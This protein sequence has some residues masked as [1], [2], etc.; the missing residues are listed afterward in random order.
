MQLKKLI[1]TA[2][3]EFPYFLDLKF[4]VMRKIRAV[5]RRPFES[6]FAA[7]P[8]LRP[9]RGAEFIDVGANRGQSIEA[10]HMLLPE[11]IVR[12]FEP[13][14][15]LFNKLRSDFGSEPWVRLHNFGLGAEA[16]EAVLFV[17]FYKRW[18]FD[19]LA[20]FDEGQARD[21]LPNRLYFYSD[22]H[23]RI[24]PLVC[25]MRRLDDLGA[26]PFFMKIDVQGLELQVLEGGQ[27]TLRRHHP[28]LLIETPGRPVVDFLAQM[29]YSQ[30]AFI[31]GQF[32]RD[33]PGKLN[34]F[35][36]TEETISHLA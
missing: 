3:V 26:R 8:L 7:L 24:E 12:S 32:K 17:P 21:W 27:E 19:G 10:I 16:T 15:V 2:Q 30:F 14:A 31:D 5:L 33:I 13:N 25:S 20:S 36:M 9:P 1:R 22:R 18:M 35:F 34:T 6:D 29:G 23:L 28:V 11:V 4:E